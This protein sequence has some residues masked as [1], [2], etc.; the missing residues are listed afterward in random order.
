MLKKIRNAALAVG[1]SVA[2]G[3]AQGAP[4]ESNIV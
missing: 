2:T 3:A 4:T 1:L